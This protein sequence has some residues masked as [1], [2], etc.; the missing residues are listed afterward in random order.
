LLCSDIVM[1]VEMFLVVLE[2]THLDCHVLSALMTS[3]S[4]NK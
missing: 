3:V 2:C 4:E 1:C